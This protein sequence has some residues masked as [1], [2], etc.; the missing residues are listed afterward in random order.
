MALNTPNIE[1]ISKRDPKLAEALKKTQDYINKNVTQA[2][3]NKLAPPT[4]FVKPA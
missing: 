1:E 3:G 2:V 4:G